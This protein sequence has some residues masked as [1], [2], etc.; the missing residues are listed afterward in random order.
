MSVA[1]NRTMILDAT[2]CNV[3]NTD[4]LG[5]PAASVITVDQYALRQPSN[6][7]TN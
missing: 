4:V 3:A 1:M 5:E 2:P 7:Q 6:Q